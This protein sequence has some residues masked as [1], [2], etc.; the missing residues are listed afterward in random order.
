MEAIAAQTMLTLFDSNE[1]VFMAKLMLAIFGI[2]DDLSI[3]FQRT[4]K[5]L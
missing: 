2:K 4:T 1:F 5:T 3:S